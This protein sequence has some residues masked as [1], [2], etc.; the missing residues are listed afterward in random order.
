MEH[1]A[2]GF[3]INSRLRGLIG[4]INSY[5]ALSVICSKRGIC[6]GLTLNMGFQY[7]WEL[8]QNQCLQVNSP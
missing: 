4:D 5:M 3:T 6:D 8:I 7:H 2:H 1:S